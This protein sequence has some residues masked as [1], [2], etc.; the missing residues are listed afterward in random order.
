M[1]KYRKIR[2]RENGGVY[3]KIILDKGERVRINSIN[4]QGNQVLTADQLRKA[5]KDTK[6]IKHLNVFKQS[7]WWRTS[8]RTT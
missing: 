5:M 1:W 7:N 3:M 6:Q 2:L 8:T 4:F